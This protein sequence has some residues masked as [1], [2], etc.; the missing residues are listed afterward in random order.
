M[1]KARYP[2]VSRCASLCLAL[3]LTAC[4]TL[5]QPGR[6][7]TPL[8]VK[9]SMTGA[10]PLADRW[11]E[12]FTDPELDALVDSALRDN[13]SLRAT[14]DRLAQAD[15]IARRDGAARLP[16][17]NL[18][19][20]AEQTS[21]EDINRINDYA[22]GVA[23]SYEL[24]LWGRVRSTAQA[25][26]FDARGAAAALNTAAISLSAEVAGRWYQLVEQRGQLA[27][28]QQ[29]ATYNEQVEELVT[30]RFRMGLAQAAD[31]LRQR[32][33]VEQTRGD[34][35]DV[36]AQIRVL[37][38][39]L[40]VLLGKAPG[41]MSFAARQTLDALPALPDT[42][43]P[44]ELIERRPD[45]REAFYR[46]HAADERVAAAIAE[47]Y[48]RI[49]LSAGVSTLATSPG[50]LFSSWLANLAARLA[51]PLFDAGR[52]MAEVDRNRAV[53]SEQL[54]AYEDTVL[55]A[56]QDVEDALA[57]EYHQHKKIASLERRLQLADAVILRLRDRYIQGATDYLDILDTLVNQ[58]DLSRRL[59]TARRELLD[60][61]IE[62]ARALAGGWDLQRP[63]ARTLVDAGA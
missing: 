49:D 41:S 32:Q 5:N 14:W 58:Q 16:A 34:S 2:I 11:W 19:S 12:M 53:V 30:L 61:R 51:V 50:D 60:F 35:E 56:L 40:A 54:N 15:A 47:R 28:L 33:L 27:L 44:L 17:V 42:G 39:Q 38:N 45:I 3:S 31:V 25:A 6:I 20:S 22:V 26:E 52:R 63:Q 24:D 8:P 37:E 23:A 21:G 18:N 46:V 29:Q 48:P 9:F 36:L 7:D 43:L 1:M 62:L 57:R 55:L 13:L 59:L 10:S 4:A